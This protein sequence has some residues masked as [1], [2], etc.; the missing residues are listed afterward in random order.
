MMLV[1]V[2]A[3]TGDPGWHSIASGTGDTP[4]QAYRTALAH[5]LRVEGVQ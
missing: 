2:D 5:V 1:L 4:A 3:R